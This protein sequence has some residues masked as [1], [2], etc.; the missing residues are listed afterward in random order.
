MGSDQIMGYWIDYLFEFSKAHDF[1]AYVV[2]FLGSYFETLIGPGFFIHGEIFFLAGSIAAGLGYLN[3]WLVYLISVLGGIAG[4]HSS[5]WLGKKYGEKFIS[6]FFR[7]SNKFLNPKKFQKGKRFFKKFGEKSLFFARLMGPVSWITPFLAGIFRTDY[8]K[9]TKYNVLGVMVGIGQFVAIGYLIGF[10]YI[11]IFSFI[12]RYFW[13]FL[14]ILLALIFLVRYLSKKTRIIRILKE[15]FV[16]IF[17]KHGIIIV[18][19]YL[20][21]YIALLYFLIAL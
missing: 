7:K 19:G 13:I 15:R 14:F 3:V 11:K 21:C 2:L 4:D 16:K 8:K 17:M 1:L 18:I 6:K 5:Y 20:I 12:E 10:A 9:F